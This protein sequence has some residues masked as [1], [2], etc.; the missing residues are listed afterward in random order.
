MSPSLPSFGNPLPSKPPPPKDAPP[1]EE[2]RSKKRHR[3]KR[4]KLGLTPK[5]EDHESSEEDDAD[6]ETKLAAS[7]EA[8]GK[9]YVSFYCYQLSVA[10]TYRY[11]FSYRGSTSSLTSPEEIAA[12]IEER[13]K[14]YPTLARVA[15]AKERE[16][17]RH[18]VIAEA[19]KAR[20]EA[21]KLKRQE[22][23]E[24]NAK[25]VEQELEEK[26]LKAERAEA[27][28]AAQKAKIKAEKLR[29]K[30]LKE[31]NRLANAEAEAERTRVKAEELKKSSVSQ[32]RSS[33][34]ERPIVTKTD[35]DLSSAQVNPFA[36]FSK[37]TVP[38]QTHPPPKPTVEE[39]SAHK[40]Y[41][42]PPEDSQPQSPS[43]LS[44]ASSE[45]LSISESSEDPGFPP[46]DATSSSGSDDSAPEEASSRH[47]GEHREDGSAGAKRTG[48]TKKGEKG[49]CVYFE[50]GHCKKGKS[51]HYEHDMQREGG[52]NA[53]LSGHSTEK[54]AGSG[55]ASGSGRKG[56]YHIVSA[57]LLRTGFLN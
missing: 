28:E 55:T 23:D 57:F 5:G 16:K 43:A 44:P 4:L 49:P 36:D 24:V 45:S 56:L 42:S 2:R 3:S 31:Q 11:E 33:V 37:P 34:E 6:E 10:Y 50:Q 1:T 26:R 35:S 22:R 54:G 32:R 13:K 14:R 20:E 52:Q 39:S 46:D 53:K 12:W 40:P 30:L 27:E 19:K 25:R 8:S 38:I 51:C 47:R 48:K 9:S 18:K 21:S 41:L 7:L 17:E 29:R 15:E